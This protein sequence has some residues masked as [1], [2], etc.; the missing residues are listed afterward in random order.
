MMEPQAYDGGLLR[1]RRETLGL[2]Y[3]DVYYKTRIPSQYVQAIEAGDFDRF[4]AACY[5]SGFLRSYCRLLEVEPSPFVKA[6]ETHMAPAPRHIV[7]RTSDYYQ[8]VAR[9]HWPDLVT[10]V[11]VCTLVALGWLAYQVIVQPSSI[12]G[13][14]SRVEAAPVDLA[15]PPLPDDAGDY[16]P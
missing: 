12:S 3:R 6:Y 14:P 8:R 15:V 5:A 10:W 1:E 9:R 4:P 16:T 11:A 7:H 2:S 13:G